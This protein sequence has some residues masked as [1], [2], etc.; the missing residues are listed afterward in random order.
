MRAN[1]VS[2]FELNASFYALQSRTMY[3]NLRAAAP[4]GM[5]IVVKGGKYIT[6]NKNLNNVEVRVFFVWVFVLCLCAH[7]GAHTHVRRPR[8]PPPH[9]SHT[10]THTQ[11]ALANQFASG[12]CAH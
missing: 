3:T 6:H 10:H 12:A 8:S 11:G 4:P 1:G 7:E 5:P 2:T 9:T